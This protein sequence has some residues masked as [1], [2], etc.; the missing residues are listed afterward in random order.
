MVGTENGNQK[1]RVRNG[2]GLLKL[3]L[4]L[5][6]QGVLGDVLSTPFFCGHEPLGHELRGSKLQNS[7]LIQQKYDPASELGGTG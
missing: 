1:G 7:I 6:F 3:S 4:F 5:V 2:P